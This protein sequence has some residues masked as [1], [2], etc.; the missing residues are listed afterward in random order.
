M[1]DNVD[2]VVIIVGWEEVEVGQN[3]TEVSE[4]RWIV[5]NSFGKNW[6]L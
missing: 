1:Y 6:G 5:Q 4:T 2:N 3:G